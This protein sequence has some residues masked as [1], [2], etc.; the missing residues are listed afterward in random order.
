[1]AKQWGRRK[2]EPPLCRSGIGE[3][4]LE[5]LPEDAIIRHYRSGPAIFTGRR[6]FLFL[7]ETMSGKTILRGGMVC[8]GSGAEPVPGELLL[9]GERIVDVGVPGTFRKVEA[10]VVDCTGKV[11]APG[12]ID[13]HSHCDIRKLKYPECRSKLLQ[14]MTTEVAGN[15]GESDSCVPGKF[16]R[17][18][19]NDLAGYAKLLADR[20]ASTNT[21]IL[22]GHNSIRRAVT[23]DRGGRPTDDELKAMR[24]LMEEA[25]AAGAAG[26]SSGLTYFPGKFAD[27]AELEFLNSATRGTGKVYATHLRSEGDKLL[28]AVDEACRVGR[29]GSGRLQVSHLK[30][31]Y[32]RN[33]RKIDALLEKLEAERESGLFLHADR[34]PYI[35]SSTYI[36]QALPPPYSLNVGIAAELRASATLRD[37]VTEALKD[38][39]RDLATTVV[40]RLGK[41]L[42]EIAAE[43]GISVERAAMKLIMEAPE[44]FVASRCMS[45][46]N[47]R[48]IVLTPWVCAGSDS[49]SMP[50]DDA[51]NI[52]HPRSVG[53]FPR[54]FRMVADELG[55][56]EAVRRMTSLPAR[57]FRI[58]ERGLIRR[59]F[60]ADLV[61]FDPAKFDSRAGFRGEDPMP[62]GVARVLVA[63]K[64]A[65]S[66]DSPERVGR[67][68][69]YIPID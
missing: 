10:A 32:A 7:G 30:T 17:S 35:H 15:C 21:V 56:G 67:F 57:I 27:T 26:W 61:V 14:G 28:E 44:E 52:G 36:R 64:L 58:P 23:G 11:V 46:D 16:G 25:F 49:I 69:R 3:N 18:R 43:A 39:P 66:A 55:V 51:A 20:P 2:I 65:W 31:I 22:C 48:R 42:S 45:P 5:K 1:M 60:V 62:S 33:F 9:E 34:Y 6:C 59:G 53:T 47:L 40:G 41:D 68:G 38:C 13:A 50:L 37:E 8:D 4:E 24:R 12:F 63:G 54:F 19:W 29:A